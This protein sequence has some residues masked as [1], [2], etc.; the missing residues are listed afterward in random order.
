MSS[1]QF[2]AVQ[3]ILIRAANWVGDAIMTTPAL[4]AVRHHFPAA[5]I[6]LLAKPW[7]IPVFE[8]SPDIDRIMVYDANGRH[9]GPTGLWRLAQDTRGGQFDLAILL[10]NAFEAALLAFLARIPRR[11][12]FTTDARTLLLTDR[13]RSWRPLKRGHLID[14]Y[15][16]LM[17]GAGIASRGRD[18]TLVLS[19]SEREEARCFLSRHGIHGQDLIIGLNPGAAFGTAKR[20]L[21]ERYAELGRRL[22]AQHAAR[23]LIFGS[24]SEA[25]LGRQMA[26]EIGNDCLSLSGQ[27]S[28]RQA[29]ALIGECDLFITNDS[30]LM[31][32]AAAL[33]VPQV[34]I[35]GPTDPTA[36]GPV[37]AQSLL[38]HRPE[39][40]YLSP[41]LKPHCP[42]IDHRCMTAI[43]VDMV[44]DAAVSLLN[45]SKA[46][47]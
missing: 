12:G 40:C 25:E 46:T 17:A 3:R 23:L 13:I 28:L 6:T 18:L 11:M 10:Q 34:A 2:S 31:H 15:L 26:A 20:W 32:V 30:G 22:M 43:S 45:R 16:G 36:T 33:D 35:I 8:N 42:I 7:V 38:V 44:M 14:Y 21:P 24:S 29:M 39:A 47:E 19:D 4:R 41:C 9:S 37:N 1:D 5:E 27:T